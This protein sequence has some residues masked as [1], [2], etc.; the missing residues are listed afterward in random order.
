MND[1]AAPC[2]AARCDSAPRL[3]TSPFAG[4]RRGFTYTELLV[5]LGIIGLLTAV[6]VPLVG[7]SRASAQ[8]VTCLSQL[9]QIGAGF[10]QYA[11]DNDKRLP[12]PFEMQISWEELLSKYLPDK[13]YFHCPADGELFPSVGSSYD[14]RDTGRPETTLA[15]RLITDTIRPDPVLAFETL[16]GWHLKGRMNAITLSGAGALMDQEECLEDLQQPIRAAPPRGTGSG[17]SP[18]HQNRGSR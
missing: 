2:R 10:F 17:G 15:G 5:S 4:A 11:A 3:P 16:P 18:G 14:W 7:R 12:D 6:I 8:S 9:R 1:A 13:G